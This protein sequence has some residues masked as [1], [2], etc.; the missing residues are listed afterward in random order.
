VHPGLIEIVILASVKVL[1]EKCFSECKLLSSGRFESG[2]K[3]PRIESQAFA[4]TALVDLII[5]GWIEV[6]RHTDDNVPRDK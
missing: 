1:G 2:S 3:L 6:S 4:G 5:P